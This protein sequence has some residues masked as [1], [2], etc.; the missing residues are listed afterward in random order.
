MSNSWLSACSTLKFHR[1]V[2]SFKQ[3]VMIYIFADNILISFILYCYCPPIYV[4][5][6]LFDREN[7]RDRCKSHPLITEKKFNEN[8]VVKSKKT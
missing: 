2:V 6:S 1:V 4:C 7:N 5:M 3:N 8:L